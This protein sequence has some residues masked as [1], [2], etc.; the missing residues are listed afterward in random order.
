[1]PKGVFG[2][3]FGWAMVK[4]IANHMED[5]YAGKINQEELKNYFEECCSSMRIYRTQQC[6][7]SGENAED[8]K[9]IIEGVYEYFAKENARAASNA[10]YLEGDKLNASLYPNYRRDD[11]TYYNSDY[12]YKCEET[13]D[14]LRQIAENM[15]DKWNTDSIDSQEI[16]KN[17]TLK[18]DG[19][20]DFNSVWN[21]IFRNQMGRSSI[22]VEA[23]VPPKD[24]TLFY[25]ESIFPDAKDANIAFK[26]ILKISI[27]KDF[28][29]MEVP[30]KPRGGIE[31]RIFNVGVLVK[32]HIPQAKYSSEL[33]KFLSNF[34]IF[35]RWY[36]Y[37]SGINNIG[38]D[39]TPRMF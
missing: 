15:T 19:G 5:F 7:T 22:A 28:Y 11:W 18:L 29:D 27:G 4:D 32:D 2:D 38:G 6:Q 35:T 3:P 1:M 31:G 12:Y 10:N 37:E 39:Y 21:F 30:F 8:N 17:S 16:E 23:T 33:E 34:S 25:K 26:G 9:K 20:F 14:I 24:F 36:S 13:K